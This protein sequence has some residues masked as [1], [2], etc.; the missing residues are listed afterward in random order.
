MTNKTEHNA[1]QSTPGQRF[2]AALESEPVLQIVGTIN[3]YTAILAQH[4]GFKAIYLSGAGVA[5]ASYGIPDVGDTTLEQ[6]LIDVKRITSVCDLPL[7]V[8]VDTGWDD[9]GETVRAMME[10]GAAGV[11]IEDQ[12]PKKRCGHLKGKEIVPIHEMVGRL[13]RA[14]EARGESDFV[15]MARTDAAAVEGMSPAVARASSYIAAG[16]DMIFAEAMTSLQDYHTFVAGLDVPVLANITEFG[17]TP[18]FTVDELHSIGVKM[19]LYPL[20]AFRAMNAA[21]LN[22]Y[23]TL[24]G[25]GTQKKCLDSMQDRN[26][27]YGFLGYNLD[28]LRS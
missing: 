19:A 1:Q 6:V 13:K 12:V 27:L 28:D 20:S 5:N 8:D 14:C 25:E 7:L 3:A 11:H 4:V 10:A 24:Y 15:I 23:R 2:R 22:V 26:D 16:A 17:R 9:P 18:L 21:A